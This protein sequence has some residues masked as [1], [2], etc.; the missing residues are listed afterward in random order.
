MHYLDIS[1]ISQLFQKIPFWGKG[2]L[3]QKLCNLFLLFLS[4][5]FFEMM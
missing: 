2:Q 4:K 1:N 5:N 3:R